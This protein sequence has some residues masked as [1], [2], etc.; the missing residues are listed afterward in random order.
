ME[1]LAYL[2]I[3]NQTF[4]I[5]SLKDTYIRINENVQHDTKISININLRNATITNTI[6]RRSLLTT[7]HAHTKS[8]QNINLNFFLS[9][10]NRYL[11]DIY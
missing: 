2:I 10:D 3:S 7:T 9:A 4:Y 5:F 1:R 8:T 11:G 6:H